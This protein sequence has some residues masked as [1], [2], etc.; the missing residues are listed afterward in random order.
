M[1]GDIDLRDIQLSKALLSR[2]RL[3]WLIGGLALAGLIGFGWHYAQ[4][5]PPAWL[6]RWKLDRY[7]GREARTR[8]FKVAFPFPSKA[9]MSQAAAS[10]PAPAKGTRTGK[11]FDALREEYLTEKTAAVLLEREVSKADQAL[12]EAS[13]ELE[14]ITRQLAALAAGADKSGLESNA[15]VARAK[16]DGLRQAPSRRAELAA[17]AQALAPIEDDL[18]DFQKAFAQVS[19]T[20][21]NS[22][23]AT[24]AKARDTFVDEAERQLRSS[25][26]Y[27]AMYKAIGQELFVARTLLE[28]KNVA[29]RREGIRVALA[30]AE[31]AS[32]YAVNGAVSARIAEGYV[33]PNLDVASDENR[34]S[35]FNED[36]LLRQCA[37]IFQRNYEFNN[38][39]R[40]YRIYLAGLKNPARADWVHERIGNA[41]E[42]AGDPRR[43]LSAYREIRDTNSFRNVFQRQI[44]R[45]EKQV[46]G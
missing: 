29:H 17:K 27:E 4:T 23:V 10:T 22:P 8:D 19:G 30:A 16:V 24:L 25:P 35:M 2:R 9:E 40:T 11:S 37:D 45:L 13:A 44:P 1:K 20:A 41:Y 33:L 18:W 15:V 36:N 14:A 3:A 26:S 5:R 7:L 21:A 38:V 28:S 32:D 34:R 6:V 39:I 31:H 43:A 42:A 12:Q 46:K